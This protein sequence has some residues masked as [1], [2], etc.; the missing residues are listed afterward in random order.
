MRT[1]QRI[2]KEMLEAPVLRDGVA[3]QHRYIELQRKDHAA[4][5]MDMQ[6]MSEENSQLSS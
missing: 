3:E 4:V 5:I 2:G 6:P 1:V